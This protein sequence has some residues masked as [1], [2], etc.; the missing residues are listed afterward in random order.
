M[1]FTIKLHRAGYL[2]AF[3]LPLFTLSVACSNSNAPVRGMFATIAYGTVT[4]AGQPG[5]NLRVEYEVYRETCGSATVLTGSDNWTLTDQ[6]GG[7][8]LQILSMDSISPQ[9]VRLFVRDANGARVEGTDVVALRYKLVSD[10]S[11][12]YDSVRADIAIP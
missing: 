3:A 1:T 9:C 11:L 10:A 12:P 7:F 8:R 6:S 4:T 5:P 2:A